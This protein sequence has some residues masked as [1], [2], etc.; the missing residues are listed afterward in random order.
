MNQELSTLSSGRT[1]LSMNIF[2]LDMWRQY[3]AVTLYKIFYFLT[4]ISHNFKRVSEL[5]RWLGE[6]NYHQSNSNRNQKR[7][8]LHNPTHKNTTSFFHAI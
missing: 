6:F 2:Y 1:S 3:N 7:M 4:R 5:H 8:F